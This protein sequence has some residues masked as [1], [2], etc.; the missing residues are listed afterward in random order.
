MATWTTKEFVASAVSAAIGAAYVWAAWSL[1]VG[2]A[3]HSVAWKLGGAAIFF[4]VAVY[5]G[6]LFQPVSWDSLFRTDHGGSITSGVLS[7]IGVVCYAIGA[8]FWLVNVATP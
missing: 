5:P 3:V 8:V 4:S 2:S 6:L 7:V 1:P